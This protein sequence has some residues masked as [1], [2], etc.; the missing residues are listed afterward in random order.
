MSS[1]RSESPASDR[2]TGKCSSLLALHLRNIEA[3][4]ENIAT[5]AMEKSQL[6][7]TEKFDHAPIGKNLSTE[8]NWRGSSSSIP[9]KDRS[10][11]RR[12]RRISPDPLVLGGSG[13]PTSASVDGQSKSLSRL[14]I[15]DPITSSSNESV[16]SNK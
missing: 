16:Y 6:E 12:R 11:R 9:R 8:A 14:S 4:L 13:V 7:P 2:F 10:P 1:S 5:T 15:K 3:E